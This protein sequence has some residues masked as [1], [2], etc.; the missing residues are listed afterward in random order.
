MAILGE[1]DRAGLLAT[2]VPTVHSRSLAEALGVRT[3]ILGQLLSQVDV[4]PLPSDFKVDGRRGRGYRRADLEAAVDRIVR[5]DLVPPE[6]VTAWR[7]AL[8]PEWG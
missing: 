3:E 4:R 8:P 5:G 7:P 2:A 1:L 6:S